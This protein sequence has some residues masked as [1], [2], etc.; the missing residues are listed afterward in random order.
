MLVA[1]TPAGALLCWKADPW[2]QDRSGWK[3]GFLSWAWQQGQALA[4]GEASGGV[5]SVALV[6]VTPAEGLLLPSCTSVLSASAGRALG[7]QGTGRE[8]ECC[9]PR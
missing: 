7:S 2:A 5:G 3:P 9:F 8:G 6:V 1:A 4:H